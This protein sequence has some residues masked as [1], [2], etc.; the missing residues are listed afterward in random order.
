[1]SNVSDK[2]WMWSADVLNNAKYCMFYVYM[3]HAQKD[4]EWWQTSILFSLVVHSRT[5]Q[6]WME[7]YKVVI[8]MFYDNHLWTYKPLAGPSY[9]TILNEA[10]FRTMG[11]K[12]V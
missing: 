11:L 2:T 10:F 8:Y 7:L 9:G 12:I 4:S 3:G 5:V 6:P 1:M